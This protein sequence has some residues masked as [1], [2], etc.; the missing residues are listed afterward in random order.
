M[1]PACGDRRRLPGD[2]PPNRPG[3]PAMS[4]EERLKRVLGPPELSWLLDRVRARIARGAPLDGVVTRAR[5]VSFGSAAR[6]RDCPAD[7][8]S[9]RRPA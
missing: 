2:D 6:G 9:R 4:D 8:R 1:T 3:S 7:S 5:L